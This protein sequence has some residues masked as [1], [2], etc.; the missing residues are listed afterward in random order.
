METMDTG[1]SRDTGAERTTTQK[2]TGQT[3]GP[4]VKEQAKE[5][6][7]KIKE[8]TLRK[9]Q[10]FVEQRKDVAAGVMADFADALQKAAGELD[11]RERRI[12]AEYVR[13][14][15]GC[16]RQFSNS[17]QEQDANGIMRQVK[18]FGQRQPLLLL[19]SAL[20]TGFAF[21][22]LLRSIDS[23]GGPEYENRNRPGGT[24]S[25]YPSKRYEEDETFR[26]EKSRPP[27]T[28]PAAGLGE[29]T[30]Y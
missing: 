7:Q 19:G 9:G 12:S 3:T 4:E 29:E 22:R 30:E 28:A 25:P 14:A 24:Q 13:S 18:N 5:K 2:P 1:K 23:D 26:Q 8:E 10:E 16:I 21:T 17:L 15:S 27:Y 20:L 11:A 6:S